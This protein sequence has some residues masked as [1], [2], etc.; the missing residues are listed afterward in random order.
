M[1]PLKPNFAVFQREFLAARSTH[2][3]ER[4]IDGGT[5]EDAVP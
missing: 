5:E 2:I 3:R 4:V 1:L